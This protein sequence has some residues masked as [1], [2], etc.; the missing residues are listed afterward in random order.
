MYH[1]ERYIDVIVQIALTHGPGEK[2][3]ISV[4]DWIMRWGS[5]VAD[6]Q[7]A[8]A[9]DLSEFIATGELPKE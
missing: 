6:I 9:S 3:S 1:L 8:V 4:S 5:Q 7:S 2:E